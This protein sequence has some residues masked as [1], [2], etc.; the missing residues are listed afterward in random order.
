MTPRSGRHR[1]HDRLHPAAAR[2]IVLHGSCMACRPGCFVMACF[3]AAEQLRKTLQ[4]S[5]PP[6]RRMS[7]LLR[8]QA[9]GPRDLGSSEPSC[10]TGREKPTRPLRIPL[11]APAVRIRQPS[12]RLLRLP[13][14]GNRL[15]RGPA[16]LDMASNPLFP[17]E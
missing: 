10:W 13:Q 12:S 17:V 16:R 8:V 9:R 4:S 5:A 7:L 14:G 2:L 15:R 1:E 6:R 3:C 11:A